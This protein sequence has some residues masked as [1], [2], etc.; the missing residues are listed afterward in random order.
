MPPAESS[1]VSFWGNL[2]KERARKE[3]AGEDADGVEKNEDEDE[4]AGDDGSLLR[5][6][7]SIDLEELHAVLRVSSPSSCSLSVSAGTDTHTHTQHDA[8]YAAFKHAPEQREAWIREHLASLA[9]LKKTVF[10]L[11]APPA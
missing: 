9:G 7:A 2:R 6:A 8:R 4:A 3:A 10:Q 5:M 11:D 1:F